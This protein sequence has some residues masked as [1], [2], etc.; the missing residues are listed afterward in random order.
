MPLFAEHFRSLFRQ[1][2]IISQQ[3]VQKVIDRGQ[4]FHRFGKAGMD[5]VTR[6]FRAIPQ[7]PDT[8]IP[9]ILPENTNAEPLPIVGWLCMVMER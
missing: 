6:L 2:Q 4:C 5:W 1:K 7:L 8:K 9:E 3:T